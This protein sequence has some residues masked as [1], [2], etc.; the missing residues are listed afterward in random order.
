MVHVQYAIAAHFGALIEKFPD[1]MATNEDVDTFLWT[2][3]PL[4]H[5]YPCCFL[6]DLGAD[7]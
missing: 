5:V 6:T 7:H 3:L 2:K 1:T 4:L